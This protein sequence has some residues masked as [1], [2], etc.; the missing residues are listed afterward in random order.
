MLCIH[1]QEKKRKKNTHCCWCLTTQNFFS[2]TA[3]FFTP[4]L[5]FLLQEVLASQMQDVLFLE[6][7]STISLTFKIGLV[8]FVFFW[9]WFC[10][11]RSLWS[12]STECRAHRWTALS[13]G[14][15]LTLHL[16]TT[17]LEGL[18]ETASTLDHIK[19][20]A[21]LILSMNSPLLS[22]TQK[23]CDPCNMQQF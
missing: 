2:Y 1:P 10:A 3:L 13:Y 20:H 16:W 19:R 11:A 9:E 8:F 4:V 18:W 12:R 5:F 22:F 23:P 7:S 15:G 17:S 14:R 6:F 21:L